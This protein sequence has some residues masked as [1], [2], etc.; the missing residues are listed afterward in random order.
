MYET[1]LKEEVEDNVKKK[2]G[3]QVRKKNM[4]QRLQNFLKN[5]TGVKKKNCF[6]KTSIREVSYKYSQILYIISIHFQDSSMCI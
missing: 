1:R 5:N 2:K 4:M 3:P 6:C